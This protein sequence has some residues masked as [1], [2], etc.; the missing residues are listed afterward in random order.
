MPDDRRAQV[1]LVDLVLERVPPLAQLDL[2]ELEVAQ[3]GDRLL[4]HLGVE[5]HQL[6]LDLG[7]LAAVLGDGRL[8]PGRRCPCSRASSR[9]SASTRVTWVRPW[10]EQRAPGP[11]APGRAARSGCRSPRR[12]PPGPSICLAI[13]A[14]LLDELLRLLGLQL[15]PGL[16]LLRSAP[17]SAPRSPGR[18]RARASSGSKA[19]ASS[20]SRS[21]V[22][23]L[24]R[25]RISNHWPSTMPSSE[26]SALALELDQHV[27]RPRP[28]RRRGR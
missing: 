18:R 23:R 10:C 17:R 28:R 3:L 26:T 8:A 14:L 12:A 5:P 6:D 27:A 4:A 24:L 9:C 15:A 7:D 19:I 13:C 22:S 2:A 25:A 11:R 20:P 1:E 16:E 21:A